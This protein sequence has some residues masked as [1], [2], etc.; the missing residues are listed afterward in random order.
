MNVKVTGQTW[1]WQYDYPDDGIRTYSSLDPRTRFATRGQQPRYAGAPRL[2]ETT[3]PMV[4]PVDTVVRLQVTSP[5]NGVI[6]SFALPAMGVKLDAVP[7]RL[8]E[9]WF[10]AE[11]TGTFYGQCSELCGRY[12]YAM[13][14]E[15]RVV[16][17]DQ[18]DQWEA[19]MADGR[20][21]HGAKAMLDQWE[22][23][24]SRQRRAGELIFWDSNR[25]IRR[26]HRVL[27]SR[28]IMSVTTAD[29]HDHA[30]HH[31]TGWRRWLYST[32]HKDIGTM[33]L[34]FAII[35]G[36]V[37]GVLSMAMRAELQEPGLQIFA[38]EQAYNVFVTA[39]GLIMVF[40]MVMPAM[41]GG[42]GN[43]IVPLHDRRARY[44]FPAPQQHLLLAA[45]A[46]DHPADHLALRSRRRWYQRRGHRLDDLSSAINNRPSRA[47]GRLRHPVAPSGRRFVDPFGRST[48][49]PPSSTCALRA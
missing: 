39:H 17:R 29:H 40:F 12:H 41:I 6:H 10:L 8:A 42:F 20:P 46:L 44:G 48:S 47:G 34:V 22:A 1:F 23:G 7:G 49:S 11:R 18:F 16:T 9:S 3:M 4:V 15:L 36:I 31:P 45:P 28:S 32:N 13:P 19:A 37:G 2:L 24:A 26:D 5:T 21:E 38:N 33:Y 30:D 25:S 43:W 14:I 35:A 27:G